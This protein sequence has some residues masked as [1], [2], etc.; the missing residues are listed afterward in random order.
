MARNKLKATKS[1]QDLNRHVNKY[2]EADKAEPL[3]SSGSTLPKREKHEKSG[4][5]TTDTELVKAILKE[6]L[7]DPDKPESK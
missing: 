2:Q 7:T 1:H 6:E 4:D 5:D 3:S